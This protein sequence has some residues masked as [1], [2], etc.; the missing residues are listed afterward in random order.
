MDITNSKVFEKKLM[1]ERKVAMEIFN[2][3]KKDCKKCPLKSNCDKEECQ[4]NLQKFLDG[5]IVYSHGELIEIEGEEVFELIVDESTGE[6]SV[7]PDIYEGDEILQSRVF[8]D[9][10][11]VLLNEKGEECSDGI[12]HMVKIPKMFYEMRKE[13]DKI[14][15]TISREVEIG[16][17]L[18]HT[19]DN[20]EVKDALYI[21]RYLCS[22]LSDTLV[23]SPNKEIRVNISFEDFNKS[24]SG[25]YKDSGY[26]MIGFHQITLLQILYLLRVR[27][28]DS[29]KHLGAGV[30]NRS[31]KLNTGG[32]YSD[33][34]FYGDASGKKHVSV[35]YV[36]DFFG[37]C[38]SLIDGLY[39]DEEHVCVKVG[40]RVIKKE[41][42]F[43]GGELKKTIGS[44]EFGF[45][46]FID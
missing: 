17:A 19:K 15:I 39:T 1:S 20:D 28:L 42:G 30:T 25:S 14:F 23:S 38:Y 9:I 33:C 10:K 24:V 27:Q 4:E 12:N 2:N 18:A 11:P 13:D 34:A 32:D 45:T 21:G 36:E 43:G 6:V 16:R 3:S 44:T 26:K 31:S 7:T 37:N 29:K 46:P 40:S 5:R 35:A 8:M 41:T 22:E